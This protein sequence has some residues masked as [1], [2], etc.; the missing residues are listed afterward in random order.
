MPNNALKTLYSTFPNREWDY[1]CLIRNK[2]MTLDFVKDNPGLMP[3]I[4][5]FYLNV[6]C[7]KDFV[8]EYYDYI[9]DDVNMLD[10]RVAVSDPV[11]Y[12]GFFERSIRQDIPWEVICENPNIPWNYSM[13]SYNKYITPKIINDNP[14]LNWCYVNISYR[15]DITLDDIINFPEINWHYSALTRNSNIPLSYIEAN[16]DKSWSW[17]DTHYKE[18]YDIDFIKRN[19]SRFKFIARGKIPFSEVTKNKY[20]PWD[21]CLM[22]C[23]RGLTIEF[24]LE[25]VDRNF[26]WLLLS[27][28]KIANKKNITKY[29]HLPWYWESISQSHFIDF[30]FILQNLDKKL[31]WLEISSNPIVSI[32]DVKNNPDLPWN[33]TGLSLNPNLTARFVIENIDKPWD[34][35]YL[36]ANEFDYS[37][38][39]QNR[40]SNFGYIAMEEIVKIACHP[41]RA[42]IQTDNMIG[43]T[44]HPLYEKW[45]KL[46]SAARGG[47]IPFSARLAGLPKKKTEKNHLTTLY[48]HLPELQHW[49]EDIVK[50]PNVSLDFIKNEPNL[51]EFYKDYLDNPNITIDEYAQGL[52]RENNKYICFKQIIQQS[53]LLKYYI[54][55]SH[56][57]ET[58]A[59]ECVTMEFVLANPQFNWDYDILIK[60]H[61]ITWEMICANPQLPWKRE[62]FARNPNLSYDILVNNI[63]IF[64]VILLEKF[65]RDNM[66]LPWVWL[67][68]LIEMQIYSGNVD[69]STP[70][71]CIY[72]DDEISL[73]YIENN[74]Q[75]PWNYKEVPY[76]RNITID[77]AIKHKKILDWYIVSSNDGINLSDIEN[78]M[79]LPWEWS[80]ICRRFDINMDFAIRN[81]KK[82]KDCYSSIS[83]NIAITLDD[84]IK[85][86]GFPWDYYELS[87][88]PNIT[89]K[90]VL[91]NPDKRWNYDNLAR[92]EFNRDERFLTISYRKS[93]SKKRNAIIYGE[94]IK[95]KTPIVL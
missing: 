61:N 88:N 69:R 75:I 39:F 89:A 3:H 64:A 78:H 34:F 10:W 8:K 26:N 24:V 42:F 71:S 37:I 73:E 57:K 22:S 52:Y 48:K 20:L 1:I 21:W 46:E 30:D 79:N 56:Y 67:Q 66:D 50:N 36:P 25:N 93:Q 38:Y 16:P 12:A 84:V 65:I 18:G 35:S 7:D 62:L 4:G 70:L 92:N 47:K 82:I 68:I 28:S 43:E 74:P 33:Y 63:P 2:N 80:V 86:Q 6:R 5:N 27:L 91:D 59:F 85:Y 53:D 19:I 87:K 55:F 95:N 58:A 31:N 60:N 9:N 17:F 41:T 77:F 76:F 94:L 72:N 40:P 15:T 83:S 32:E 49:G 81:F 14:H 44:Y 90:Y 23:D 54:A 45:A 11:K 51:M 29:P 13:M